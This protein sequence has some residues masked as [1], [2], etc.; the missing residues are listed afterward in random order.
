MCGVILVDAGR[1]QSI[2]L[3]R[4]AYIHDHC[5]GCH[6]NYALLYQLP[7]NNLLTHRVL[8]LREKPPVKTIALGISFIIYKIQKYLA[9]IYLLLFKF[10][11]SIYHYE[12]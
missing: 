7:N 2:R 8:C 12:I 9:A 6:H 10:V 4:D 5:L 1:S 3:G 11:L